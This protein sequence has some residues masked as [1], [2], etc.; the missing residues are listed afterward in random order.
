MDKEL[1]RR[2]GK[3]PV[4][5]FTQ[6][7]KESMKGALKEV[8][9]DDLSAVYMKLA[10]FLQTMAGQ[11][12]RGDRTVAVGNFL[13]LFE[14]LNDVKSL[15]GEWFDG[16]YHNCEASDMVFL[17][18]VAAAVYSHLR[19]QDD[20]PKDFSEDM[21]KRLIKFDQKTGFFEGFIANIYS[22]MISDRKL[23]SENYSELEEIDIWEDFQNEHAD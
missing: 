19:Q 7:L 15:H 18:D 6:T 1:V 22:D 21:D 9:N 23:Q 16:M 5:D 17:T 20:L 8:D 4:S 13:A 3:R 12:K 2:T 10:P 14:I 11:I